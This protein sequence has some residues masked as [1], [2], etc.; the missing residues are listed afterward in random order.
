MPELVGPGLPACRRASARRGA[1]ERKILWQ[2]NQPSLD[3]IPLDVAFHSQAFLLATDEVIVAFVLPERRSTQAE[4]PDGFVPRESLER[5]EPGSGSHARGNEKMNVIRHDYEG[6]QLVAFKSPLA[7]VEGADKHFRD[8]RLA[9]K[10]WA[11]P[12]AIQQAI[13]SN[14][15]LTRGKPLVQK[16]AANRQASVKAEGYEYSFADDVPMRKAP[17]IPGHVDIS[18][19]RGEFVSED[20]GTA[21]AGRK[22]GG[23]AEAL[24]PLNGFGLFWVIAWFGLRH[25]YL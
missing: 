18:S 13:H 17:V 6:V 20:F 16:N 9:E 5:P 11:S 10:E 24:T 2:P 7:F 19:A 12:E 14:E 15:R 25:E 4:H 22:P 23:R 8:F 1:G 3:R 21:C